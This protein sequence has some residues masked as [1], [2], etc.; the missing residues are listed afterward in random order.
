[1]AFSLRA[2][3]MLVGAGISCMALGMMSYPYFA[4]RSTQKR[5]SSLIETE[6]ALTGSQIQRG[7]YINSGSKDVGRDP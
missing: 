2:R 7:V 6:G 1:M 3:N 5:G 4:I